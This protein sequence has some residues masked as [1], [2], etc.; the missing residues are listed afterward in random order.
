[1]TD[2]AGEILIGLTEGKRVFLRWGPIF[3]RRGDSRHGSFKWDWR[4]GV[5]W[6]LG[7]DGEAGVFAASFCVEP[8][9]PKE[10]RVEIDGKRIFFGIFCI[11]IG[12]EGGFAGKI[13]VIVKP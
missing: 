5:W 11:G 8:L 7:S 13:D 6:R 2:G 4:E 3:T 10:E 1:M 9:V 12:G